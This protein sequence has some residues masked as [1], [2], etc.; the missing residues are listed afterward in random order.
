MRP[1]TTLL[2]LLLA[3]Q[4]AGYGDAAEEKEIAGTLIKEMVDFIGVAMKEMDPERPGVRLKKG[5]HVHDPDPCYAMAFLYKNPHPLNPYYKDDAIRDKAV[6]IADR[7]ATTRMR[8]EWPLYLVCQ[9]FDLL[10][11]EIPEEKKGE[12]QAY[13]EDYVRTE[14]ERPFFRT[15]PN[16]EAINALAILR[17]GQV[18]E[19]P[20]WVQLAHRMM[21]RLLKRQTDLGYFDEGHGPSM[22]Y[23]NI[24]LVGMLLFSDYSKDTLTFEASKR[25]ADFMIRYSFPDGS[26]I[27]TLDGRQ[28]YSLGYFGT[29]CYGLD[30]WPLGKELNR[31]IFRT[32]KKREVLDARS[33][34]YNY[35]DWYAY[36]SMFFLV[37]EFRSLR[38]EAPVARLPQDRNGYRM[39]ES[40]PSFSGGVVRQNDWMVA[41][42]AIS[43][44][45]REQSIYRLERQ[46]RIDVWHERAGLVIGGGHNLIGAPIP[47]ANV[48]LVPSGTPLEVNFGL[49]KAPDEQAKR[50]AYFPGFVKAKFEAGRQRLDEVF[51]HG[52]I[53]LDVNPGSETELDLDYSLDVFGL[54]EAYI[55]LPVVVFH[56]RRLEVDGKPWKESSEVRVT[57]EVRISDG[58]MGADVRLKVPEGREAFLRFPISP[59]RWLM[60]GDDPEQQWYEP[61]YNI[62]L[63]SVRTKL[64]DG[65]ESGRFVLS[66]R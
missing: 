27:G 57:R 10:K 29:L 9:V 60:H 4:A 38:S 28:S 2:G 40:G 66:V 26:T 34:Y 16:H 14:A 43:T 64:V 6:A 7:I 63:V 32:R 53:S 58:A 20:Q 15:S 24:Q 25:L 3:F 50:A 42:S 39:I 62:G 44:D 54:K 37:D 51:R 49:I 56:R 13:A 22:K 59:I 55:Q 21:H 18:F 36:L 1:L 46:S 33:R 5:Q 35:S 48:V 45:P 11:D 19:K 65:R 61:Y 52:T 8:P 41:L 31:R 47:L 12:W 30:R 17:A 23:N